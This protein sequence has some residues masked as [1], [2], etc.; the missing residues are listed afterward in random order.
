MMKPF[1]LHG[2]QLFHDGTLA[3]ADIEATGIRVDVDYLQ[4]Q[5]SRLAK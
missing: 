3:L 1:S 5:D 4:E 2:Y